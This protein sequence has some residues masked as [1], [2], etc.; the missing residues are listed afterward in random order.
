MSSEVVRTMMVNDCAKAPVHGCMVSDICGTD[1]V[2]QHRNVV[3][4]GQD[5]Q[6][7]CKTEQVYGICI[8]SLR[9]IE[10]FHGV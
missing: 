4:R 8:S 1:C 2:L 9:R 7:D 3:L 5:G 10:G 6:A